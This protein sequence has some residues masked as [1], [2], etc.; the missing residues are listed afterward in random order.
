MFGYSKGVHYIFDPI[1]LVNHDGKGVGR[2]IIGFIGPGIMGKPM[3]PLVMDRKFNPG[4][5]INLHIKDLARV[6]AISTMAG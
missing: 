3:R 6:S 4:F 1:Y 5:R 2:M